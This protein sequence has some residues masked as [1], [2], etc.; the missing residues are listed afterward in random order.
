MCACYPQAAV[1]TLLLQVLRLVAERMQ[2]RHPNICT[3]MGAS[4]EPVTEDP[5]V[6]CYSALTYSSRASAL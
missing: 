5:L 3:V 6:V 2:L 4:V 1:Y